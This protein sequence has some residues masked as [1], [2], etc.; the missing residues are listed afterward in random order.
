MPAD[1]QPDGPS[2]MARAEAELVHAR[3]RLALSM[4]KLER[5]VKRTLD[6]REWVR[7][8]PVPTLALAFGLGFLLGRGIRR[9]A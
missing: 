2:E 3:E 4:G 6:W 1:G 5:E 9:R 7:R 8:R